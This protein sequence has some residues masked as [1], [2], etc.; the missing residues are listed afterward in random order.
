MGSHARTHARTQA[1]QVMQAME[2]Q[3]VESGMGQ[4]TGSGN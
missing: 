4:S 2:V 1:S 3:I